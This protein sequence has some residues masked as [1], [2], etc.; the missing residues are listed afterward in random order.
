LETI[1]RNKKRQKLST[2]SKEYQFEIETDWLTRKQASHYLQ[3][4][5]STL[6]SCIPIRKFYL[7]K[8]VRYYKK[9]LDDYLFAHCKDPNEGDIKDGN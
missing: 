4:G 8:S 3:V 2:N 6:D 7:G 1:L 9:D 5:I